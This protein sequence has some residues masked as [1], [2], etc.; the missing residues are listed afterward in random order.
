MFSNTSLHLAA[1]VIFSAIGPLVLL[2]APS[3]ASRYIVELGL[4]MQQVGFLF[5]V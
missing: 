1:V 5:T 4:S 3:L 2:V